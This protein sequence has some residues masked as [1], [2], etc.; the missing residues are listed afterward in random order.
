MTLDA[1]VLVVAVV[2][3]W[4]ERIRFCAC[5]AREALKDINTTDPIQIS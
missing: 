1:E 3:L 2:E 4:K 5:G